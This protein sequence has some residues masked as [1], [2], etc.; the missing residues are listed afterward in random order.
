ML[1]CGQACTQ[2]RQKVQSILPT[3]A[4]QKECKLAAALQDDEI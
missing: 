2:S 1:S 3:F 4:G